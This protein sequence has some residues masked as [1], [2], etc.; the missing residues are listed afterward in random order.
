[1]RG[2]S[3][4]KPGCD[5]ETMRALA[6]VHRRER[7]SGRLDEPDLLAEVAEDV[8]YFDGERVKLSPSRPR[9]RP[10]PERVP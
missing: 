3:P 4:P 6:M 2:Y 10:P 9:R 7:Q 5:L 1:M 8:T